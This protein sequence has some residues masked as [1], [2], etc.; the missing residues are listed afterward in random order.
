M[1]EPIRVLI[2]DDHPVVRRGL[3]SA[4]EISEG[5]ELVGEAEDGAQAI[6]MSQKL[7]PDVVLMDLLMPGTDGVTA[8]QSIREKCPRSQI[9]VLTSFPE[10]DLVAKAIR[11]G[12]ISYLLKNVNAA[13]LFRAIHEAAAGRPTL[14]P[15]AAKVLMDRERAP[16]DEFKIGDDL[17][18]RER[19]VLAQMAEGL[20][21]PGI[22]EKLFISRATASVHVSNILSKLGAANR[23]EATAIAHRL[24]LVN[25]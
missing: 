1:A 14:A 5:I 22:A 8:I 25:D 3:A 16:R 2:V 4:L 9:V 18:P 19:E 21:N 20:S 7:E 10:N 11:A 23:T 12:A 15:E 13:E 17:T 6:A 24:K